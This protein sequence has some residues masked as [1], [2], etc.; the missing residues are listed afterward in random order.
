[1][2]SSIIF[3]QNTSNKPIGFYSPHKH[4]TITLVPT[5][6]DNPSDSLFLFHAFPSHV[7]I[8]NEGSTLVI[9][10]G[11]RVCDHSLV[12]VFL[13][14]VC[15]QIKGVCVFLLLKTRIKRIKIKRIGKSTHPRLGIKS[16]AQRIL[17]TNRNL[18]LFITLAP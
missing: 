18:I 9:Y 6:H 3:L 10:L 13:S 1:L 2:I 4:Y 12:V 15:P 11:L 17:H 8:I 16:L 7:H 14:C 5:M